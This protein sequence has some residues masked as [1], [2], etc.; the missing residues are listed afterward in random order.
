M[1][2][3]NR[4]ISQNFCIY[5]FAASLIAFQPTFGQTTATNEPVV[6]NWEYD[7]DTDPITDEK[8]EFLINITDGVSVM[9]QRG[10][11]II[12]MFD[13]NKYVSID[14]RTEVTYR[15]DHGVPKTIAGSMSRSGRS[16]LLI[17]ER[18][19]LQALVEAKPFVI[20]VSTRFATETKELDVKGFSEALKLTSECGL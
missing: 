12:L 17:N 16:V 10:R 20:R 4:S 18:P 19:L 13:F 14:S 8:K 1:K 7:A 11:P 6:G 5:V 9:C 15:I 2:M 3:M